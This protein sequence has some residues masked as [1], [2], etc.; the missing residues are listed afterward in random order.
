M[1]PRLERASLLSALRIAL[2][3]IGLGVLAWLWRSGV[4]EAGYVAGVCAALLILR[5]ALSF[6]SWQARQ[7][8][9]E[10]ITERQLYAA[11]RRRWLEG[12]E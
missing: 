3:V 8:H 2:I 5:G 9:A 4:R 12:D 11:K 1:D 7:R 10:R 6:L